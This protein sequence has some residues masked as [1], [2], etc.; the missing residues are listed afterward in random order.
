MDINTLRGISTI[1]V[2]IAFFGVCWWAFSP[3]RKAKF[4][5]AA[6]LPFA[7]EMENRTQEKSQQGE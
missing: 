7:D 2:A 4:N 1:L 5:D 6:N 3:K